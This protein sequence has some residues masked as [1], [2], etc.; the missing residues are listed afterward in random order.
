MK[1]NSVRTHCPDLFD[2]WSYKVTK[3]KELIHVGYI[4]N[5]LHLKAH[6]QML[7]DKCSQPKAH[8]WYSRN[9]VWWAFVQWAF[10]CGLLVVRFWPWAFA[11]WANQPKS[12]LLDRSPAILTSDDFIRSNEIIKTKWPTYYAINHFVLTI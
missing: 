4:S 5:D 7:T 8:I 9:I 6:A 3:M 10:F 11:W 2:D 12:R 1:L